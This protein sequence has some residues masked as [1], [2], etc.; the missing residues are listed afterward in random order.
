MLKKE[1]KVILFMAVLC[2]VLL[3]GTQSAAAQ[4]YLGDDWIKWLPELP[5]F[6]GNEPGEVLAT[7]FIRNA[8]AIVRYVMGGVALI[9]GA[10]Y[11]TSMVFSRGEEEKISQQK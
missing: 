6:S 11:A 2:A 1:W 8:V 10:V 5:F 7:S 3:F 4:G 9:A